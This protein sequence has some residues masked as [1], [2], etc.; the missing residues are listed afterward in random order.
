MFIAIPQMT[1]QEGVR[2]S[3]ASA[4]IE[5]I[6]T[7]RPNLHILAN[8]R[9]IKL[10]FT[11][12]NTNGVKEI[13]ANEVLF[14]RNNTYHTVKA[15]KEIIISCGS[16]ESPKLLMLSGIRFHRRS[17]LLKHFQI[18][19]RTERSL[20]KFGNRNNRRSARRQQLYGS[21]RNPT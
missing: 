5:S 2:E 6:Y 18:R 21:H 3:T 16:I 1:I 20:N 10:M 7:S 15:R 12:N 19:N 14:I 11:K 13:N 4:F 8:S 17:L 9:A